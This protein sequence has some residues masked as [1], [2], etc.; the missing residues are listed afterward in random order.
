[1][2]IVKTP[3][4][5]PNG[6]DKHSMQARIKLNPDFSPRFSKVACKSCHISFPG[7][8]QKKQSVILP[9]QPRIQWGLELS[10]FS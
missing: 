8:Q 10:G 6:I 7:E 3:N 5:V 2:I 1:M 4:I 9:N